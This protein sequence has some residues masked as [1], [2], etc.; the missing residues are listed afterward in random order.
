MPRR[1]APPPAQE[2]LSLTVPREEAARQINDR[3]VKGSAIRERPIQDE[4]TLE[5]AKDAYYTWTEYNEEMLR[6]MFTSPELAD[7]YSDESGFVGWLDYFEEKVLDL[8]KDIDTKI[9]RL[10]SIQQRLELIPPTPGVTQASTA[11]SQKHGDIRTVFVVHGHDEAVREA[12][13]RFVSKLDLH[14]VVLH[15]QAS[16]GRTVVEKLEAHGDVGFA[17][18]LLT[19]DDVGG[20]D[21]SSLRPRARQNVVL[22]LGYFLGRLQRRRVCAVHKG[23][24]EMPSDYMGVIYIPFDT[25]GGWRLKLA[26]ELKAAGLPVDMNKAI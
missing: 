16:Q 2:P 17:I 24:L 25:A 11:Q 23:D 22:E 10:T 20:R 14:P 15:E 9:R 12:V 8:Q 13:A 26:K 4:A 18:I 19:P 6:Q 5:T 1:S 3:I 7:E 21:P